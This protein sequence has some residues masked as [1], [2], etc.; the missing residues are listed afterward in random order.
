[1]DCFKNKIIDTNKKEAFSALFKKFL[2]DLPSWVSTCKCYTIF[3]V[4]LQDYSIM[5]DIAAELKEREN[6]LYCYAKKP[7]EADHR[8]IQNINL[9]SGNEAL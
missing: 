3:N 6:L 1:M 7:E 9:N 2:E 5:N 4:A 8:K